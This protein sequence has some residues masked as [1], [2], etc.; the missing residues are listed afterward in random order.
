MQAFGPRASGIRRSSPIIFFW[1]FLTKKMESLIPTLQKM[2]IPLD[3][4]T[5]RCSKKYSRNFRPSVRFS[6]VYEPRT[7]ERFG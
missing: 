5:R 2:N 7:R 4:F 1:L 6:T 3:R